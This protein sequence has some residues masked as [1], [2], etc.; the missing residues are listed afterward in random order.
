MADFMLSIKN[1]ILILILSSLA[2]S[3]H[4]QVYK[5]ID[6]DGKVHYSDKKPAED[7]IDMNITQD[8]M[9]APKEITKASPIYYS[10]DNSARWVLIDTLDYAPIEQNGKPKIALFYF[11]GDC[12]LPTSIYWEELERY[13]PEVI[14]KGTRYFN[15]ISSA[16]YGNGYQI[17]ATET[18][19][20]NRQLIASQAHRL[21][22]QIVDMKLEACA[23]KLRYNQH[24]QNLN[25][26]TSRDFKIAQNWMKI[27]WRLYDN[28]SD[29]LIYEN[30]SE[31]A[32]KS[33]EKN[34]GAIP[35][36][37]RDSLHE[38][39]LQLLSDPNFVALLKSPVSNRVTTPPPP[40]PKSTL[41][42]IRDTF[43]GK[44]KDRTRFVNI[45]TGTSYLKAAATEH[46]ANDGQ[47]ATSLTDLKLEV[48]DLFSADQVRSITLR[49]D[50]TID[51]D[52]SP[53]FGSNT[54][55]WLIP[56]E[57]NNGALISWRC[58]TNVG[59]GDDVG[60]CTSF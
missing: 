5:W 25:E 50:G 23:I 57:K 34:R 37:I 56:D 53:A 16:F 17:A 45:L 35:Y 42:K 46:Y 60:G 31:G 24:A 6:D 54:A 55:I 18:E 28:A 48:S 38:A 33:N 52:V 41:E 51:L 43:T 19:K 10:G 14:P 44:Y 8:V 11:G 7:A 29:K 58:Q 39:T 47:W 9:P 59:A 15:R 12:A 1:L 4:S 40:Q 21:E 36:A 30:T 3:S 49:F 32:A 20:M 27:N 2:L 26:F 22:A 13:Y